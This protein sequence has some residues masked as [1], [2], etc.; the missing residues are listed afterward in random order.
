MG[1]IS[2]TIILRSCRQEELKCKAS[3]GSEAKYYLKEME[4]EQD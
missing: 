2:V 4:G 3:L 1:Y